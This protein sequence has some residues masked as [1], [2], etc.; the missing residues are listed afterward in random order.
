M[1]LM[2]QRHLSER[3]DAIA[4]LV[5]SC[6]DNGCAAELELATWAWRSRIAAWKLNVD[7]WGIWQRSTSLATCS[8]VLNRSR[9][10][11]ASWDDVN[12]ELL[13]LLRLRVGVHDQS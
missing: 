7:T 2:D 10:I 5:R 8:I 13:E 6:V 9:G 3:D 1:A 4:S 12:K 11:P